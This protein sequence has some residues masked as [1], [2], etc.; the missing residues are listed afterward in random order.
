M[1]G[2]SFELVENEKKS[3]PGAILQ[4]RVE[5]LKAQ[6]PYQDP[7]HANDNAATDTEANEEIE[8]EQVERG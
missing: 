7:E 8:P 6:D 5:E 4:M 1:N 3:D 2:L